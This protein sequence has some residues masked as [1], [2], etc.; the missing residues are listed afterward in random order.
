[1]VLEK[2]DILACIIYSLVANKLDCIGLALGYI[3]FLFNGE[4]ENILR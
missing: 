3:R 4:L 2:D 1:V